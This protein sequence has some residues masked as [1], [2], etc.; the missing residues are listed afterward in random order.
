MQDAEEH[1]LKTMMAARALELLL[2]RG[3]LEPVHHTP[4]SRAEVL[5]AKLAGNGVQHIRLLFLDD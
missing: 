1:L 3:L 5:Q 2:M 4:H